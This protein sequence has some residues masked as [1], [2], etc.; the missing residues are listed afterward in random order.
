MSESAMSRDHR[1]ARSFRRAAR[2]QARVITALVVR[3]ALSRYGHENLGFF[4]VLA[5]PLLFSGA[6]M[7]LWHFNKHGHMEDVGLVLFV[8]SGYCCVTLW[9]HVVAKSV[10]GVSGR[11]GLL[12]HVHIKPLDLLLAFCILETIGIFAAFMVAYTPLWA[13]EV[14]HPIRD[15]LLVVGGFLFLG[16]FAAAVAMIF[17]ALSEKFEIMEKFI[18]ATMYVTLPLTGV[19]TLVEWLPQKAQ[20]VMLYSPMVNA[21]EMFRGGF[22]PEEI[23]TKFS[24][25]YLFGVCVTLSAIGVLSMK[26]VQ[27]H[28]GS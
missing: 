26:N 1:Q 8:L 14:V 28:L 19:F 4:W 20:Q 12:Y 18:P 3:E 15:P 2:V 5:E 21:V 22:F 25:S 16:W 27:K 7:V 11:S 24:A 13:F 23:V 17:A 6:V 9:R 10:R